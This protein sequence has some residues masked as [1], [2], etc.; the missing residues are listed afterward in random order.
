MINIEHGVEYWMYSN[1]YLGSPQCV[2][3][4]GMRAK[5]VIFIRK[6][7]TKK[8]STFGIHDD[9]IFGQSHL[10]MGHMSQWWT[11]KSM[12]KFAGPL[13]PINQRSFG[14]IETTWWSPRTGIFNHIYIY[15]RWLEITKKYRFQMTHTHT[16]LPHRGFASYAAPRTCWGTMDYPPD[17]SSPASAVWLVPE[18]GKPTGRLNS[19]I[20]ILFGSIWLPFGYVKIAI[21]HGHRNSGFTHW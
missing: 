12:T 9:L 6:M 8:R 20:C 1:W 3:K 11:E 7:R 5:N 16:L 4:L 17:D 21:E 10:G 13:L 2:R 19:G 18:L 14:S 15:N